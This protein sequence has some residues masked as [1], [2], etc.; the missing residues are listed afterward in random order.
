MIDLL[1][2]I[3]AAYPGWVLF[4]LLLFGL[5]FFKTLQILFANLGRGDRDD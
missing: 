1:R 3:V 2:P 5:S 4:V